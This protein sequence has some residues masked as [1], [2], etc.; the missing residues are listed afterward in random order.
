METNLN[1]IANLIMFVF[2]L[3]FYL[4]FF[5]GLG[6]KKSVSKQMLA[7]MHFFRLG[8]ACFLTRTMFNILTCPHPSWPELIFNFF[9]DAVLIGGFV[10]HYFL[11][12]K[13]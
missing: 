13:K 1:F 3:I 10:K 5:G 2:G 9:M 6:Q 12:E 11:Y 8:V 7:F 4:N